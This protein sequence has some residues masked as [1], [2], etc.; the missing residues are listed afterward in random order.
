[1]IEQIND[2]EARRERH[3]QRIEEMRRSKQKQMRRR[4]Y[5]KKL[6]P[7]VLS[8]VIII[9][10]I[11]GMI[12]VFHKPSLEK[13]DDKNSES[14]AENVS[15]DNAD[16]D[17]GAVREVPAYE[18][19]AF[20]GKF[21]IIDQALTTWQ[22][23]ISSQAAESPE[24]YQASE[25]ADTVQLG[26]YLDSEQQFFSDYAILI[27]LSDDNIMAEKYAN[28]RINPAS[29]TK[30]LTVLV[31][32][33]HIEMED[34]DDKFTMTLEITDYG[35][36]HDCSSAGFVDEEVISVKDLFYGTV[37]PSGADAAVGLA[38]YV[39]GSQEAFV[40]LMNDKLEELGLSQTTHFTNCVGVYDENHYSTVYDMAMIMEAAMDNELC[41]E[42]MSAHTYTTMETE[43]HP[44]GIILSNWF[45]RRIEDKEGG[46]RVVCA[47]TGFVAQ[48]GNCAASYTED[49]NGNGYVCVTAGA[50]S[51]FRCIYDHADLYKLYLQS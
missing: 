27:D 16:N 17:D 11:S 23:F 8:A 2:E 28:T 32:A 14:I 21:S 29:M 49:E 18:K 35:Y 51:A 9:L 15:I 31:A 25:T 46:E 50:N 6:M 26:A 41:R 30:I 37:L 1:M 48:S 10:I 13:Q 24:S 34:L 20:D 40:E 36:T 42:V 12:R 4:M 19:V 3:R 44:E 45:L 7:V 22:V 5:F 38:T 33:E 47:K 43:Q 39:A